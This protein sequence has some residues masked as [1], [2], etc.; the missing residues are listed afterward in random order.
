MLVK[1]NKKQHCKMLEEMMKDAKDVY[2]AVAFLKQSGLDLIKESIY[3]VLELNG[4]F[5]IIVGLDLYVTEPKALYDLLN[6][7]QG[8]SGKLKFFLFSSAS[9]TFHPK[10]YASKRVKKSSVLIGSANLTNGGLSTNVEASVYH[11]NDE[12]LF[13]ECREFFAEIISDNNCKKASALAIQ[14]YEKKYIVFNKNNEKAEKKSKQEISEIVES[15]LLI[16]C[17]KEYCNNKDEMDSLA[18]KRSD[19]KEAKILIGYF[20]SDKIKSK[21]DFMKIYERLVGA[22]GQEK[23]WHSGSIFRSKNRVAES[24]QEFLEFAS[25]VSS[26][27]VLRKKPKQI[28][29]LVIPVKNKILGL[30]FNVITEFLNTLNPEKFPVLNKNPIDSVKYLFAEE[31]KEPGRFKGEDYQ[32][33]AD[34]MLQLRNDIGAK[35][36]I[37]TDHFLNFVYWKY[38]RDNS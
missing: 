1:N 20:N 30:G 24:Y 38:A 27:E 4:S 10:I 14:E 32:A 23:L 28:F 36:F 33:Y 16:D 6:I 22:A 8:S 19:Y 34:F 13:E 31:F 18:S 2:V 17:Y 9:A 25:F 29:D 35:D 21:S 11:D 12:K 37:E 5:N 3:E 15:S 26:D 7:S